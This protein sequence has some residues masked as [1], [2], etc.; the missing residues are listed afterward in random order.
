M[1][2]SERI[3]KVINII[4]HK[5]NENSSEKSWDT[6]K[7]SIDTFTPNMGETLIKNEGIKLKSKLPSMNEVEND[8]L[9]A[10][11]KINNIKGG[12][13]NKYQQYLSTKTRPDIVLISELVILGVFI[14]VAL[15]VIPKLTSANEPRY[16]VQSLIKASNMPI[17]KLSVAETNNV[18]TEL[19]AISNFKKYF[20]SDPFSDENSGKNVIN[21]VN[22]I[23][24]LLAFALQ[25]I[26][27]PFIFGYIIWFI[28]VYWQYV[29]AA[30]KGWLKMMFAYATDL[31]EGKFGCKWYVAMATGWGCND[32]NFADYYDPWKNTYID[33]PVYYERMKYIRK[34]LWVKRAYYEVPY[35][36]YIIRP[37]HIYYNKYRFAKM[38][39]T[40]RA[41]DV[42]L[43]KLLGID[44]AIVQMPRDALLDLLKD[45]E[46]VV[47][48]L[49]AKVKQ[50]K[51]QVD[52]KNYPSIN[53][54][55]KP[56]MCPASKGPLSQIKKVKGT[57]VKMSDKVSKIYS[58]YNNAIKTEEA[59]LQKSATDKTD[60]IN[61]ADSVIKELDSEGFEN[62]ATCRMK[63]DIDL[64][65][66]L[67]IIIF[68][69]ITII[70]IFIYDNNK[71]NRIKYYYIG[72]ILL[73]LFILL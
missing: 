34:F 49:Y 20:A 4:K 14:A 66:I 15:K 19:L 16:S 62:M 65:S 72:V 59:K 39:Y 64:N 42:L 9:I 2:I 60:M 36:K 5:H 35:R 67:F 8:A 58:R 21:F 44:R 73:V 69:I 56:C 1:N 43:L 54:K 45:K 46:D 27:P 47:P 10:A 23:W 57:A 3:D 26:I 71:S 52:N 12:I 40:T 37:K 30:F 7:K 63:N 32:V 55:G 24:P 28:V 31:F 17:G 38:L 13:T 29:F 50:A 41:V 18:Q 22:L 53:K 68:A 33:I 25:W 61:K 70:L 48:I 11:A 6:S 51:S